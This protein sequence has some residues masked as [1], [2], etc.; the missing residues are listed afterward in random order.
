MP[1]RPVSIA[2]LTL[3]LGGLLVAGACDSGQRA[4]IPGAE[5]A[6]AGA[7]AGGA[8]DGAGGGGSVGELGGGAAELEVADF[9]EASGLTLAQVGLGTALTRHPE[10]YN[11]VDIG[12]VFEVSG[13]SGP[14]ADDAFKLAALDEAG[15][16][17]EVDIEVVHAY[18]DGRVFIVPGRLLAAGARHKLHVTTAGGTLTQG[19]R[20]NV[21]VGEPEVADAPAMAGDVAAALHLR[22][23]QAFH[24]AADKGAA[25]IDALSLLAGATGGVVQ[26]DSGSTTRGTVSLAGF[27]G[28][29]LDGDGAPDAEDLSFPMVSLRGEVVGL[30]VRL[31]GVLAD[32]EP[33]LTV[34]GRLSRYDDGAWQMTGGVAVFDAPCDVFASVAAAQ[35]ACDDAGG[36]LTVVASLKGETAYLARLSVSLEGALSGEGADRVAT[37]ALTK[38]RLVAAKAEDVEKLDLSGA[39]SVALIA[40]GDTA[41]NTTE[42]ADSLVTEVQCGDG[43]CLLSGVGIRVG[44]TLPPGVLALRA[45]VGL[46]TAEV[47]LPR[48]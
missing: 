44:D 32:G 43:G 9:P 6:G 3:L 1:I 15:A 2:S 18:D 21:G 20:T 11:Y 16:E 38:P 36:R 19:F 29:D 13:L 37:V 24:P 12:G 22:A 10:M 31:Q 25:F 35:D 5:D 28:E 23:R 39:V 41:A 7:P 8:G 4:T 48:T 30:Y 40:N 27:R 17:T 26:M 33:I 14:L 42:A 47:P 34:T 46:L 45:R